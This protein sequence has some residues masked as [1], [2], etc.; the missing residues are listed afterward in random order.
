MI[1]HLLGQ[2]DLDGV[3]ELPINN[4]R[5]LARQDLALECHLSN[6]E[7]VAEKVGE[8]SARERDAADGFSCFQGADLGDDA[9]ITQV[10]QEPIEAAEPQITAKDGADPVSLTVIDGYL[11]V[12]GVVAKRRHAADP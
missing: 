11:A 5:L 10:G 6:V 8:R 7:S 1:V 9:L 2:L 4:G 3:E 12:L